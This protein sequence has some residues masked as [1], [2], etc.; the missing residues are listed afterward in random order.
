M[1]VTIRIKFR[2]H[3]QSLLTLEAR[4]NT[5][6]NAAINTGN[7]AVNNLMNSAANAGNTA[8]A[9]IVNGAAE[10]A[11]NVNTAVNNAVNN[12]TVAA[13]N[14][15]KNAAVVATNLGTSMKNIVVPVVG[16]A[17]LNNALKPI[18]ASIQATPIDAPSIFLSLP[19]ILITGLTIVL[20]VLLVVF[21]DSILSAI[22]QFMGG[23]STVTTDAGTSISTAISN[24]EAD[25]EAAAQDLDIVNKVVPTRKQVFNVSENVYTYSDAEPLCKA[26]GAELATYDQVQKAWEKGADWCNYG[27][28]RGQGAVYPTQQSTF[29]TLQNGTSDDERLACGTVGI[30]GGYMDNPQLRF[31]VNCYGDKPAESDH[32]LKN[33]LQNKI[34]PLTPEVLEQTK[35]E[36]RYKS[37][38]GQIGVL[39]FRQGA[40]SS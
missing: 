17:A 19:I 6:A 7:N 37:E 3:F 34:P 22:Q 40:W 4:M 18:N 27:W 36:L 38:Q 2:F 8:I 13:N 16:N 29:N 28:I 24:V 5:T 21:R 14:V 20:V 25:V 12:A 32:D 39:P 15:A 30:N 10:A 11:K 9:N 23:I 26:L 35:K 31:G 33:T 1:D